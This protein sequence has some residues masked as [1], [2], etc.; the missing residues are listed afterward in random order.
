[1]KKKHLFT[2]LLLV[3]ALALLLG[4]GYRFLPRLTPRGDQVLPVANCDLNQGACV[5][6]LPD[7][8][9]MRVEITPRPIPVLRPLN[10]SLSLEGYAV[11]AAR[12]NFSGVGMDMGFNPITLKEN[13]GGQFTGQGALPVCVNG[14]MRWQATFILENAQGSLAA[15]FQFDSG[16]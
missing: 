16:A 6:D 12:L 7:G 2:H 13:A 14:R 8:G 10:I 3:L 4:A 11:Q 5:A 9:K 1:M 15:P